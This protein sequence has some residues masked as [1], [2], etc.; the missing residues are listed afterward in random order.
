MDQKKI[1]ILFLYWGKKGGG[2][3]YSLEISKELSKRND[4]NLHLS[5][6]DQCEMIDQFLDLKK[7]VFLVKTYR[8]VAG[9]LYT[10]FIR[11]Y[12]LKERL[13]KYL[14]E[15]GIDVIIIGMDFFWGPIINRAA[16][17]IGAGTIFVVHEPKPHPGESFSMSFFKKRNLAKS[18][19]GADH[20]VTLT[21]HVKTCI[22]DNYKVKYENISVIPHG[23]FS[24]YKADTPRK[25]DGRDEIKLL[26][27]GRIDY[28]KGLDILLSAFYEL[29]QIQNAI[30]L[31]IWG[32]GDMQ[33]YEEQVRKIKNLRIENRWV[34]EDE[35]STIFKDCDICILPYRDA[36]Q[37]GITGIAAHAAMPIVACPSPGLKEQ[38]N[39]YGA[40]ISGEC[41]SHSLKESLLNLVENPELYHRLSKQALEYGK[42]MSWD[43]IAAE[44]YDISARLNSKSGL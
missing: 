38:L 31:E 41:T 43:N 23:A 18:I 19:P 25:L 16:E 9:F 2:A 7:P 40:V 29:E 39:D 44:F 1:N 5:I 14:Q 13:K 30:Q 33:P 10:Y 3:K 15:N 34:G 21:E 28:Y 6:S 8:S 20:V 11:K 26:Y 36:S 24:Y 37:S 35:I 42:E 32:S 4:V 22:T 12:L 27:F 17:S